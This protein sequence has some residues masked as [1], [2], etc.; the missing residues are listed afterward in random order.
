MTKKT[1]I[2]GGTIIGILTV[3]VVTAL[4]IGGWIMGIVNTEVKLRN[5]YQAKHKHVE[6]AHDT[7]WKTISQKYKISGDYKNTFLNGL[8]AVAMGRQGGSV[9]K[10]NNESSAQLGLS[11]DVFNQM[12]ATIEGQ[13]ASLKREQDTLTDMWRQHKTHCEVFPNSIFVGAKVLPEPKMISSTRTKEAIET[14]VDD[15][16]SM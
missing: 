15:D 4:C 1:L 7:M 10:S 3:L 5:T 11:T 12:M 2:V 6:T 13:R 14:G 16:I 9:F 8:R